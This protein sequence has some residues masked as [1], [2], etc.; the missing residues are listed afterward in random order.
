M[1]LLEFPQVKF[2]LVRPVVHV[3]VVFQD[4]EEEGSMAGNFLN[5]FLVF[6]FYKTN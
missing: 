1:Q 6:C 5:C 2:S 4:R 3:E